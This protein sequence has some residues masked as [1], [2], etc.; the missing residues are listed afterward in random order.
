M[1]TR[2]RWSSVNSDGRCSCQAQR[3]I[4][5]CLR[6]QK[7]P[8]DWCRQVPQDVAQRYVKDLSIFNICSAIERAFARKLQQL[9]S[10]LALLRTICLKLL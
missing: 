5:S 3:N 1:R 2:R 8:W 6:F 9:Y 7:R 10:P 4:K